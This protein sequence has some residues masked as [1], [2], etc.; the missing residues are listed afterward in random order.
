MYYIYAYIYAYIYIYNIASSLTTPHPNNSQSVLLYTPGITSNRISSSSAGGPR[1]E[2]FRAESWAELHAWVN[3]LALL[4]AVA[5]NEAAAAT[6]AV[7]YTY[8]NGVL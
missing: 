5:R 6:A 3:R 7:T 1:V 8:M 2:R 4:G